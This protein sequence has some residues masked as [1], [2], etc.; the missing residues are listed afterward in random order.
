MSAAL[1]VPIGYFASQKFM[2]PKR[3]AE[4]KRVL[5]PAVESNAPAHS[6]V[7]EKSIAVLPFVDMSEKKDQEVLRRRLVRGTDRPARKD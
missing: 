4:N 7:P 6:T 3:V 2:L 5:A 1:A